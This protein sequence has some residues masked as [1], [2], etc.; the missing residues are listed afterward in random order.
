MLYIL[1]NAFNVNRSKK[2]DYRDTFRYEAAAVITIFDEVTF[3][4]DLYDVS[5]LNEGDPIPRDVLN[6]LLTNN[7][8][9]KYFYNR[10]RKNKVNVINTHSSEINSK[11][12]IYFKMELSHEIILNAD[13]NDEAKNIAFKAYRKSDIY[14]SVET[15]KRM[16]SSVDVTI[17]LLNDHAIR[18]F[19]GEVV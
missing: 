10:T 12:S 18:I 14:N 7:N 19:P 8:N 11:S 3:P 17:N 2:I 16:G 4:S 1:K 15:V 6:H 13:N 5:T 9:Y